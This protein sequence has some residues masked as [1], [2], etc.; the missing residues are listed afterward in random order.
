MESSTDAATAGGRMAGKKKLASINEKLRAKLGRAPIPDLGLVAAEFIDRAGGPRNF[1]HLLW[2]EFQ[3][4]AEGTLARQRIIELVGKFIKSGN[5]RLTDADLDNFTDDEL[6]SLLADAAKRAKVLD[7]AEPAAQPGRPAAGPAA[8]EEGQAERR[9][10]A[11]AEGGR[12]EGGPA[13]DP[14]G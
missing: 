5:E 13:G 6:E 9:D 12:G 4:A 1:G 2:L 11:E 14:P 10:A 8:A 3:K 7:D